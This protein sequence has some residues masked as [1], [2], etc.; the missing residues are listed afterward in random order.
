MRRALSWR[1]RVRT[2]SSTWR[3]SRTSL[4]HTKIRGARST[5]TSAGNSTLLEACRALELAPR[6]L[7]IGSGEEYGRAT[8]DELP[9]TEEHPLSPENPYS[10]SKVAQDVM[11]Y[12]YFI[13]FGLPVIR[14]RPFNHVG[15]GQSHRFVLAAFAKQVAE[16]EGG[17]SPP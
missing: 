15:P 12:Q 17:G 9:L 14:M 6:T 11:G 10:V 8:A 13:S 1:N 3:H 7:V 5:T 4:Q 2:T 16:I